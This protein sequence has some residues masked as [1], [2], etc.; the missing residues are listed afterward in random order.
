MWQPALAVFLRSFIAVKTIEESTDQYSTLQIKQMLQEHTG[1]EI[2]VNELYIALLDADCNYLNH[3]LEMLWL[4]K[5]K[6]S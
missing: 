1:S 2:D 5:K 4:F 6:E 3:G